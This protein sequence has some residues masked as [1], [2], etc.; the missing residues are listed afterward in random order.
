M[1]QTNGYTLDSDC[2]GIMT[3]ANGD[4][5]AKITMVHGNDEVLGMSVIPGSNLALHFER[6]LSTCTN[7]TLKGEYGF[8][9][10]GQR[11]GAPLLALGT[12]T[13]D[14]QGNATGQRTITRNGVVGPVLNLSGFPY[15]VN[16]DCTG[17]QFD[18]SGALFSRLV[19][20]Q[21]GEE[22][23]SMSLAPGNNV[24][25]HFERTK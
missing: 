7:A 20:V 3:D 18:S 21:N 24:V 13:F 1:T 4:P 25:V 11:S 19:V 6:I 2:T 22:A 10:N 23:L 16:P 12:V 8:Q 14:G 15:R 9:R 17:T 5:I